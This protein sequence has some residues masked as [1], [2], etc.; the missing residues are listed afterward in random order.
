M[1]GILTFYDKQVRDLFDMKLFVEA[2]SDT[3]LT[4]RGSG[5]SVSLHRSF[6]STSGFLTVRRDVQDLG[7]D[8]GQ[9]LEHYITYVKPAFEEFCLPVADRLA[10]EL[11]S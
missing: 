9:T 6:L 1:E 2:D 3:R 11:K 8:I 10:G 7:R 4:R 5:V